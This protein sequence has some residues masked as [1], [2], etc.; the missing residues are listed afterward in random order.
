M[1]RDNLEVGY[2]VKAYEWISIDSENGRWDVLVK[3]DSGG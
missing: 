2:S 3:D 1:D